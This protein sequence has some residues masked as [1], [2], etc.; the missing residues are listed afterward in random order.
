[1][2]A[3]NQ[4]LRNAEIFCHL[5]GRIAE[6]EFGIKTPNQSTLRIITER[7]WDSLQL[8]INSTFSFNP[9]TSGIICPKGDRIQNFIQDMVDGKLNFGEDYTGI[10]PYLFAAYY[11]VQ[12][13]PDAIVEIK[14]TLSTN[15]KHY[16]HEYRLAYMPEKKSL[17]WNEI[18]SLPG[19]KKFDQLNSEEDGYPGLQDFVD[20]NLYV[21]PLTEKIID[22]VLKTGWCAIAAA[23]G[24]GKTCTMRSVAWKFR[25]H[26][27]ERILVINCLNIENKSELIEK[28]LDTKYENKTLLI[29]DNAHVLP[30]RIF[31][32]SI[33][34]EKRKSNAELFF[35]V[36]ERKVLKSITTYN[37]GWAKTKGQPF[38]LT[39][40]IVYAAALLNFVTKEPINV[41]ENW[42]KN[43][44]IFL[45][46][47]GGNPAELSNIN[48]EEAI[49]NLR[50][51]CLAM[52]ISKSKS[53]LEISDIDIKESI[54]DFY[55]RDDFEMHGL[56]SE[57]IG[58][59]SNLLSEIAMVYQF[60]CDYFL[61]ISTE[62]ESIDILKNII[63][64]IDEH[65]SHFLRLQHSSDA[66]YL[67]SLAE[68]SPEQ[69]RCN[70]LEYCK[71]IGKYSGSKLENLIYQVSL[72]RK[73]D[74]IIEDLS[75]NPEFF[76]CI[77][78][79][80]SI[81]YKIAV[82]S[83][84]PVFTLML[85][86]INNPRLRNEL[87][88]KHVGQ[89]GYT[90]FF[91]MLC[92]CSMVSNLLRFFDVIESNIFATDEFVA[93]LF[94]KMSDQKGIHKIINLFLEKNWDIKLFKYENYVQ[95]TSAFNKSNFAAIISFDQ[96]VRKKIIEETE[97]EAIAQILSKK[98]QYSNTF[99][100]D[101]VNNDFNFDQY[102]N[103]WASSYSFLLISILNNFNVRAVNKLIATETL[104]WSGLNK[105]L[106]P[107]FYFGHF[108]KAVNII[109][110]KLGKKKILLDT[111]RN[112]II[113]ILKESA[114]DPSYIYENIDEFY[115]LLKAILYIN[116][117]E[118]YPYILS[119]F[120]DFFDFLKI[121]DISHPKSP[122]LIKFLES[123]Y[124]LRKDRRIFDYVSRIL[125]RNLFEC[126]STE[127]FDKGGHYYN[128]LLGSIKSILIINGK[129]INELN[130]LSS[131]FKDK[132][133]FVGKTDY[134]LYN[135]YSKNNWKYKVA[136]SYIISSRGL[137]NTLF[138]LSLFTNNEWIKNKY[139]F[140][141]KFILNENRFQLDTQDCVLVHFLFILKNKPV[142]EKYSRILFNKKLILATL[143]EYGSGFT[144]FQNILILYISLKKNKPKYLEYYL[145]EIIKF[146]TI[147]PLEKLVPNST[148]NPFSNL[149][150]KTHNEI[151]V[152]FESK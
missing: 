93:H 110:S 45:E 51:L 68:Q 7:D 73:D 65:H 150:R 57:Q 19:I 14:K 64:T 18:I 92:N 48:P 5:T 112:L 15:R 59:A 108:L 107:V 39:P 54:K 44:T 87:L 8:K 103:Y 42:I 126:R 29:I 38:T 25:D 139:T 43:H 71:K 148:N 121:P 113:K 98:I 69:L 49:V 91:E 17:Q 104:H 32:R 62:S 106:S 102:K 13:R 142:D 70:L 84:L 90:N 146:K 143:G 10:I 22:A 114:Y 152:A 60:D 23:E 27:R 78:S 149:I 136:G 83:H 33:I 63:R 41:L 138:S 151:S 131:S 80:L 101:F 147:P 28:I 82:S 47:I 134:D 99:L 122:Y 9:T 128:L 119:T 88:E 11:Y 117:K 96:L 34:L 72:F 89:I 81:H 130:V 118:T 135:I 120:S 3:D 37:K 125:F 36:A 86:S 16:W 141:L 24:R 140:L 94:T 46:D 127:I 133:F 40:S 145:K 75:H 1:M 79:Y 116:D 6:K 67:Y 20:N 77:L 137:I 109:C 111:R 105:P 56:S 61:P 76:E 26:F 144:S 95:L 115:Y 66:Y 124:Y 129:K 21:T 50:I 123:I 4:A 12:E 100:I 58:K 53:I 74:N 2:I 85:E 55:L 30:T 132:L 31:N 35:L 97:L 52:S